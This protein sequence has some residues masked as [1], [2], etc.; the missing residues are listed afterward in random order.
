VEVLLNKGLDMSNQV[1]TELLER[2]GEVATYFEG[3]QLDYRIQ[4]AK[5][6]N[7]LEELARLVAQGEAEM[8]RQEFYDNDIF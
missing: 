6:D 8:S 3:K 2:A 1:N 7:D 5:E 4:K